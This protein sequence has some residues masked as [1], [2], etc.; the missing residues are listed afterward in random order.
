MKFTAIILLSACLTAS[1]KGL[2]QNVTLSLKDT[3]LEKVFIELKK[4]TGY[5]FWYEN[6]LLEK[7]KPVTVTLKNVA[8]EEALKKCLAGQPLSFTVTDKTIV[9]TEKKILQQ[10]EIKDLPLPPIDVTGK[11]VNEVGQPV[12]KVSVVVKGS[13]PVIGTTTDDNGN[14][15]LKGIAPHAILV[16]SGVNVESSEVKV[17]NRKNL[18]TIELKVRIV[19]GEDVTIKAYTGY[20]VV[21]PTRRPGSYVVLDNEL[22]NRSVSTNILD[23]LENLTSGI[24]N[25]KSLFGGYQISIRGQSTIS[26]DKRPLIVIDGFPYNELNESDLV[27]TTSVFLSNLNPNDVESV[28]VLRDAAAASIWGA[29]AGNGVIVITTKKGNYNQKAKLSINSNINFLSKPNLYYQPVMTS[30]DEI[31]FERTIFN[32]GYF[33]IYD[34]VFAGIGIFPELPGAAEILLAQKKGAITQQQALAQL[35]MLENHDVRDDIDK[36]FKRLGVNRQ[37]SLNLSGGSLLNN[38]YASVGYDKNNSNDLENRNERISINIRNSY[39]PIRQFEITTYVNYTNSTRRAGF[40]SI[41][42]KNTP[43][44]KL[45]DDMGNPLAVPYKYRQPYVDTAKYQGLLD[46]HYR[47]LE[48]IKL[49]D[50]VVRSNDIR[51]GLTA[52]YKNI[53]PGLSGEMRFQYHLNNIKLENYYDPQSF[54]VRDLVNQFVNVNSTGGL[55]YPVPRGAILDRSSTEMKS[56]NLRGQLNY[57]GTWDLHTLNLIA[58]AEAGQGETTGEA[59]RIYGYDKGNASYIPAIDYTT[60]FP[61]RPSDVGQVPYIPSYFPWRLNRIVSFFGNGAYTFRNKYSFSLS[62]RFDGANA[63]GVKTNHLIKPL[64]STGISWELSKERFYKSAF[65]PYLKLRATYG[66][67]GNTGSAPAFT[68]ILTFSG[69]QITGAPYAV[70]TN[71]PN[72]YLRWEKN[73]I[74]NLGLNFGFKNDRITGSLEYYFKKSNDLISQ[75]KVDPTTGVVSYTGNGGSMKGNGF[76]LNINAVNISS[77]AFKWVTSLLASKVT[78]RVTKLDY[79][80]STAN[81]YL[82]GTLVLNKPVGSIFSYRWGGL[83]SANGDPQ[84]ILGDSVTSYVTVM[85]GDNTK[86]ENLVFHG[87]STPTVMGSLLNTFTISKLSISFNIIFKLK[88]YFRRPSIDYAKLYSSFTGH[89]DYSLRWRNPGDEKITSVPSLPSSAISSRDF[90]YQY[91]EILV[92]K[93][94]NIRF[95]DIRISYM[96]DNQNW[97]KMPFQSAQLYA[98][99]N[100]IGIIWKANKY[101]IDPEFSNYGAIPPGRSFAI[102]VNINF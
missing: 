38:Y 98:N 79:A 90:F 87:S 33:D 50:N 80:A 99:I 78:N 54:F 2:G 28:T 4:Q 16:F 59:V 9:I 51:L 62:G 14:F 18:G 6:R 77:R 34:A 48:E 20:E 41:L 91:S 10:T 15:S 74:I 67:N 13:N 64:W 97:K 22:L 57:S 84:G 95:Q 96:L 93:A 29:R 30:K 1:A 102:G 86:P 68:G 60:F 85:N 56:W 94:D 65:L 8:L 43:Y 11:I 61:I 32:T 49:N 100:N 92:E 82:D 89:K 58:G 66:Y 101:D 81:R 83:S 47:P 27:G 75:I 31:D 53:V 69:A 46:W 45:A 44:R 55:V 35:S 17:N 23:R 25:F 19:A 7:T 72:P 63:F 5:D 73:R 42:G 37:Y 39:R 71:A 3:P 70:L 36:Y 21:D 52:T 88:Y 40:S 12:A 76:D 26:A 24:T